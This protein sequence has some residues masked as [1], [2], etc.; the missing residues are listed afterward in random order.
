MNAHS[1][2]APKDLGAALRGIADHQ[3]TRAS[4][5]LGWKGGH[6]HKGVHQARKSI[7]RVRSILALAG[8]TLGP[9][10]EALSYLLSEINQG[11][12]RVRDAQA[13]VEAIDHLAA[14]THGEKWLRLLVR[15]R[16]SAVAA[17]RIVLQAAIAA[18]PDFLQARNLLASIN[19]ALDGLAWSSVANREVEAAFSLGKEKTRKAAK[20]AHKTGEDED[21][22]RWRRKARR[23]SQQQ[24]ILAE[25]GI[26][27]T[28]EYDDRGIASLLGQQQDCSLLLEFCESDRS[29]IRWTDRNQL[30][31]LVEKKLGSLRKTLA[32]QTVEA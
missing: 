20:K 32:S 26:K 13:L 25:A 27:S 12:S 5:C 23:Q 19:V 11:L 10:A 16:R 14:Q 4:Q 31:R 29:P 1:K 18:D 6:R 17:R 22:H 2:D 8:A 15:A 9:G 30:N 7:R 3:L 21:W 24:R 28:V